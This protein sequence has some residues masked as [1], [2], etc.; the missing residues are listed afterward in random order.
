MVASNSQW[1]LDL[2]STS[3]TCI[4]GWAGGL[5]GLILYLVTSFQV[6]APLVPGFLSVK[7]PL[8]PLNAQY[9]SAHNLGTS[10]TSSIP[11]PLRCNW[12]EI[13]ICA[14]K[15]YYHV[16][17][18]FICHYFNDMLCL[19]LCMLSANCHV[20]TFLGFNGVR[21]FEPTCLTLSPS[22]PC[23]TSSYSNGQLNRYLM[24][25]SSLL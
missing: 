3:I 16:T 22:L 24:Q 20:F 15:H 2:S 9:R 8:N 7:W 13:C 4:L 1:V 21:Y 17:W 14:C 11:P 23:R 25:F 5:G 19:L 18:C 6:Q 10:L 12:I